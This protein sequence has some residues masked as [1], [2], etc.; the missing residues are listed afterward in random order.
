MEELIIH[1]KNLI[2]YA[3]QQLEIKT[4]ECNSYKLKLGEIQHLLNSEIK[5]IREGVIKENKSGEC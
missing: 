4:N 2:E 1:Y 3:L 5:V